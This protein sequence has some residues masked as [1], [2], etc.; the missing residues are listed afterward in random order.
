MI[1]TFVNACKQHG[2]DPGVWLQDVLARIHR[3]PINRIN[4][5]LPQNWTPPSPPDDKAQ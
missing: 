1:Y 4:E 5:L 3:H 2:I